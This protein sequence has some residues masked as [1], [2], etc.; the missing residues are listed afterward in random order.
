MQTIIESGATHAIMR[1]N[2]QGCNVAIIGA[3]P[4]GLSAA[5]CLRA[6]GVETRV[7]GQPMSFWKRHMPVGMCLRSP[8]EGSNLADPDRRFTL[9]AYART[10]GHQL[11]SPLPLE[12]FVDYGCWFQQQV[13]PDID[14]RMVTRVEQSGSGFQL[15]LQDGERISA[16]RVI[17]AGGIVP[18]AHRPSQFL[19]LPRDL[20]SHSCEH[21]DLRGFK[22]KRVIVVGGGQS[23]LES[24]ALLHEAGAEVRV[25]IR[26]PEVRWTWQRPWL[27]TF[28]PIGRLLYAFPDVGPAGISHVVAAPNWFRRL[29]RG[30]Q[31]Q[32]SERSIRAAGAGWLK[33]RLQQIP[34]TTARSVV[35]AV[36][37]NAHLN[38]RL[39]D[40]SEHSADH[41]LMATGYRV[42][43]SKYEFLAP[44]LLSRISSVDGYPVLDG[45]FETSVEGLHFL[46]A[47]A[48]WSF[49]PLMRFV[50]G[51]DFATRTLARSVAKRTQVGAR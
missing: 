8:L 30:V 47:P 13:V 50:A 2:D 25:V 7:F 36:P 26:E 9:K 15:T 14:Q 28:R 3:G 48:A 16:K 24:T 31:R 4:Y 1:G 23:A 32:W 38:V 43:I 29:P 19:A 20:A 42:N 35:S 10:N 22:G 44:E 21:S 39:D 51:A 6:A 34:L 5:A 18:F 33:P 46:G 17:V 40:G 49:G 27:H 11:S 41:L 12:R 45:G 37:S